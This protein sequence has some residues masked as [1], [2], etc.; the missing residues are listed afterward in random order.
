[1]L[2]V[3][4][5]FDHQLDPENWPANKIANEYKLK[6]PLVGKISRRNTI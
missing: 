3:Y 2:S 1:M 4:L 6:E 5:P